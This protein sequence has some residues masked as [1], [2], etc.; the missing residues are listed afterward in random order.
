MTL[1][2]SIGGVVDK[3]LYIP[4]NANAYK[5]AKAK[6]IIEHIVLRE[7]FIQFGRATFLAVMIFLSLTISFYITG[8]SSLIFL[9]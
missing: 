2:D 4:F 1:V 9:I 5:E 3:M 7:L 6:G 8:I